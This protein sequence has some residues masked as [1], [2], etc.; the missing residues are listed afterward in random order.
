MLLLLQKNV[1]A[2]LT[3]KVKH[4]SSVS[5]RDVILNTE[6]MLWGKHAASQDRV[7]SSLSALGMS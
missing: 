7:F 6:A 3:F 2:D 5:I 4:L 1:P